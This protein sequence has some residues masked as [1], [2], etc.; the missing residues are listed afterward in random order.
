MAYCQRDLAERGPLMVTCSV[1][2]AVLVSSSLLAAQASTDVDCSAANTRVAQAV[3][4]SPDLVALGQVIADG[5]TEL[6]PLAD[7]P[8]AEVRRRFD[9]LQRLDRCNS[10]RGEMLVSC[11]RSAYEERAT[12][13]TSRL[14]ALNTVAAD[15]LAATQAADALAA[16]QAADALAATQAADARAAQQATVASNNARALAQQA[17]DARAAEQRARF[18]VAQRS[19]VPRTA[20][21]EPSG[22]ESVSQGGSTDNDSLTASQT[23]L[24][25]AWLI[26]TIPFTFVF[27][28]TGRVWR[29]WKMGMTGS[30][31]V[32][33]D[34]Q[35]M[36]TRSIGWGAGLA[37]LTVLILGAMLGLL[38]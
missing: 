12:E 1:L 5:Y 24:L 6:L 34:T 20:Q 8:A 7:S 23:I 10:E 16:T 35:G 26:L 21:V 27:M 37:G 15:A 30:G 9:W 29:Q 13:I 25:I 31:I 2:C 36:W 3:C 4:A 38:E 18:P 28:K 32:G 17:A 14:G 11:V 19:P 33:I 22:T